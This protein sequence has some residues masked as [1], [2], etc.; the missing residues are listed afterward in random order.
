[1]YLSKHLNIPG[2]KL[3]GL[4]IQFNNEII[5]KANKKGIRLI[6]CDVENLSIE[7]AKYD[8]I[9]MSQLLEHLLSPHNTLKRLYT[10]LN[11]D[12]I[13][14]IETPNWKS[15]DFLL[16]KKKY[17]GGYHFPRHFNI[18]SPESLC[19]FVQSC[20]FRIVKQ[21]FLSSPAS[22]IMS[23]RNLLKMNSRMRSKSVFEFLNF[24]S[25]PVVAL[26]ILIDMF[27]ILFKGNTSNQF[28]AAEKPRIN[29]DNWSKK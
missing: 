22:W 13:I 14:V 24:N 25:L 1:M 18:F 9:F 29:T 21:G 17:W 26:F 4:D 15:L 20:G 3:T 12:G 5:D 27:T 11:P 2:L 28:L 23:F 19:K 10:C 8:L 6:K 7:E 16:F